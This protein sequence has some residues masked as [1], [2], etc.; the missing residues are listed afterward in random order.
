MLI[1]IFIFNNLQKEIFVIDLPKIEI[2]ESSATQQLQI[3][4]Q[5][6]PIVSYSGYPKPELLWYK[7]GSLIESDKKYK[8]YTEET[9]S[10]IAI[11]SVERKD[12][13]TYTVKAINSAGSASAELFLKVIGMLFT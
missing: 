1:R 13:G 5:W 10:T 3:A 2:D 6:K 11:Y 8:I 4:S 7:N 9:T 12:S